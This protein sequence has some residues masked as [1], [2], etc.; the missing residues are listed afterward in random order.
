[1]FRRGPL[2][3]RN[4]SCR[5]TQVSLAARSLLIRSSFVS[6]SENFLLTIN[7]TPREIS[8]PSVGGDEGEGGPKGFCS[9]HPHPRPPPSKGEGTRSGNLKYICPVV[10]SLSSHCQ[11][12]NL[13]NDLLRGESFQVDG[14]RS[15]GGDAGTASLA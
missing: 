2:L 13:R 15:A 1:M 4:T 9:V 8:P 11:L 7:R 6:K 14:A 12:L 10:W 3:H 5:G